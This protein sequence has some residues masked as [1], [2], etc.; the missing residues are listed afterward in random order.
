MSKEHRL[1][2]HLFLS[3]LKINNLNYSGA[4]KMGWADR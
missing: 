3:I 1:T 4:V 2:W